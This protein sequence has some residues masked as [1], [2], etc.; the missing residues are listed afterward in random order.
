MTALTV[1]STV[2]VRAVYPVAE[3]MLAEALD[4]L[5]A[6]LPPAGVKIGMLASAENVRAVVDLVDRLKAGA[7][8]VPVVLDPVVRSS[9]GK[10]LL[11]AAGV[12]LLRERL[13]PLV[14]WVTPNLLEAGV[15][16]GERVE[17]P[18]ETERAAAELAAAYPGL[19]VIVT[20]GHLERADDLV[21]LADGRAEW[22][23][24]ERIAS[25]A[26]HGTGCAF[27]SALLCGLVRGVDGM[28]AARA[29]KRFVAEA[30]RR[31]EPLGQGKGPM[32][33]LW[34]LRE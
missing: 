7:G 2:G 18:Q 22:L 17:T 5:S 12:G 23:R 24:G 28:E 4:F 21:L 6:D 9:S 20:G 11:N 19:N 32:S 26:T 13:L 8:A 14:D 25:H 1:Q 3:G 31:A 29:A 33:L 34:P 27:S 16:T 15:L 30:I 10:E